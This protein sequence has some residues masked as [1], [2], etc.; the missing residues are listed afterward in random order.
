MQETQVQSLGREDPLEKEMATH[1]SILALEIPGTEEPD[2]LQSM[3]SEKEL[4]TVTK[5]QLCWRIIWSFWIIQAIY[6][7]SRFTVF[8]ITILFKN[9]SLVHQA[10]A[11]VSCIQPGLVICITLN[12]IHVSMMFSQNIPPSPSPTESKVFCTSVSLFLF[13]I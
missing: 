5:G 2:W 1:S 4:D 12:N 13:C 3:R 6:S 7:N 10:W 11:L 8:Y 9:H